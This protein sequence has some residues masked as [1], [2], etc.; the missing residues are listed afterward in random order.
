LEDIDRL[1]AKDDMQGVLGVRDEKYSN[2]AVHVE[3][4]GYVQEV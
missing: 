2:N 1:F 4:P 3:H